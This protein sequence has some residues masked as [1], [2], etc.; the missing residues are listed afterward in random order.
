[1]I[2]VTMNYTFH[3][4]PLMYF[5]PKYIKKNK[6]NKKTKNRKQN[7]TKKQKKKKKKNIEK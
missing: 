1:M 2:L 6:K 7:K 4:F 5:P 3:L